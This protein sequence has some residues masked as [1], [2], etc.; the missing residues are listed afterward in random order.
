MVNFMRLFRTMCRTARERGETRGARGSIAILLIVML[1]VVMTG[2]VS[3]VALVGGVGSQVSAMT[4][5][6]DQ[7]FYAAEAG[8]Q[9][10]WYEVEYGTWNKVGQY[11]TSGV[12]GNCTF[13]VTATGGGYGSNIRVTS[14][15][16]YTANPTLQVT[17]NGTMQATNIA[18]AILLGAGINEHGNITIDGDTLVKGNINLGGSVTINNGVIQYGGTSNNL[19]YATYN[20]NIPSPPYVW[21]SPSGA[22]PP[23]GNAINTNTLNAQSDSQRVTDTSP[24]SLDFT[25]HSVLYIYV[26]GG[27]TLVLKKTN[28]Y[29]SGTLVVI[30]DVSVQAGLGAADAPVNIVTTGNVSTVGNLSIVGSIYADGNLTHQGQLQVTGIV[31]ALGSMSPTNGNGAGGA[32]ITRAPPPAFDPRA[33]SGAGSIQIQHFTGPTL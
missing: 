1:V 22:A 18:P 27:Q 16:T 17:V 32:T 25:N 6:R 11:A 28:I 33:Y 24:S 23:T 12:V 4:L 19:P 21:F 30:G 10:I 7:A 14:V 8:I 9:R 13:T 3:T 15:G 5:H 20:A 2:I 29:G 31:N 26:P